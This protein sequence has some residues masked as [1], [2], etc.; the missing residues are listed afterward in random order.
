MSNKMKSPGTPKRSKGREFKPREPYTLRL[1]KILEEYPDGSQVLREILQNSDDAKS[2]EQVFIL[3]HNT[4]PSNSV[5]EPDL[6]DNYQRTNLKL[7]RYQGPALLSK[8]NTIFEERDFQ[9]LL[10]LANSEKRDQFDKIGVMGV[11]FNSIY[12]ITDSPSFIT[13]DKY[14]ILDPHEWYFEG[15]VQFDFV[16]EDLAKEYPHQFAPFRI[17]CDKP[18]KGTLFRYPLRTTEDSIDSNISKK[19]Y[20]PDEILEMFNKFYENESINCLLFLK[21]IECISFYELK[22]GATEPNLLYTIRL[23]NANRVREQRHL[24]VKK[25]VSMMDSLKSKKL[26]KSNQSHTTYVA[27]FSR[28]KGDS[29][30]NREVSSWLILN[31]L[32]DIYQVEA[33]FQEKFNKDIGEYKFIPNVGLAVPLN[34]LNIM[35][36]L[37]CFL[38]LPVSMPFQVS[39]NGYFAVSTNRR[40]LWSAADNEDLAADALARLKVTWNRYL[41]ENILP[42]AWAEFLREIPL[43]VIDI[44]PDN[45]Y[46]FW[47]IIES[48]STVNISTFCKDL[49]QNVI[50][51]LGVEDRVFKGPSSSS[52]IGKVAN[53]PAKSYLK[54]SLQEFHWL[55]LSNGYFEDPRSNYGLSKILGKIGF[56]VILVSHDIIKALKDSN[57]EGSLR[58]F[59]PAIIRTYLN[60]NRNRWNDTQDNNTT[61]TISRKEILQLFGYI[62][63]DKKF[64]ELEGFKMIPLADGTLGTLSL[65]S[66]S[67]VYIC[68]RDDYKNHELDI[69]KDQLDNFI[70]KSIDFGLYQSL[71][72]FAKAGWNLNIKVLDEVAVANMIRFS[73]K[74]SIVDRNWNLIG[75]IKKSLSNSEEIQMSDHREWVYKLWDNL[76]YRNWDLTKF[77]DIPL[78]PTSRSTLRKLNTPKKI[79]SNQTSKNIST[80]L[81]SIFEKFGAVFVEDEFDRSEVSK[82][83]KVT[84]YIIRPDDI[85]SVLNSLRTDSSYPKNLNHELKIHEASTLVDHLSNH[86]RLANK[87][88]FNSN[89]IEIIKHLPI[90]IEVDHTYSIPLLP[91]KKSWYLLPKSDE[92]TYGKVIYPSNMGGFLSTS[93]QNLS[94]I[95]E[96]IIKIPRLN[97][98]EYWKDYVIPFL[99]L[100][101]QTDLDIV[102]DKLFDKLPFLLDHDSNLKDVLGRTSFVPVGTLKMSLQQQ[103]P[104]N[105]KLAKPTELFDP[106]ERE[107]TG[108][109]FEEEQVFPAGKYGVP[110]ASASNKFF[111]N[112]KLL[113]MRSILSPDDVNSRIN[114]IVK[115]RKIP[116]VRE[117]LIH[118]KAFK[119]FKYIDDKWDT[120]VIQNRNTRETKV[121]DAL[122][123]ILETEWIP[124][125]D[126]S[127]KKIFS[128]RQNCYSQKDKYL[129]CLVTPLLEYKVKNKRF[130]K[131]LKWDTYPEVKTVLKQLEFC[132]VS[133]SNKQPPE[134]LEMICNAIYKYI[135]DALRANDETSM[136]EADFMKKCLKNHPWILCRNT[137]HPTDKVVFSLPI[138]FQNNNSS[139]VE[140]PEGYKSDFWYLFKEMG[141]RN[142][143]EIKDLIT[144]IS[145]MGH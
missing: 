62:L 66:N 10:K 101:Q 75:I 3:D 14:V 32:D 103:M 68:P 127:E 72:E 122:K 45:L 58:Y 36:R 105:I 118:A 47:P 15:G 104:D 115:K 23:E 141:V 107:I 90:F 99:Y 136:K 17:P 124:T 84:R 43:K 8:N 38:P 69:F 46:R 83:A 123:T 98:Y 80:N 140:L 111:S 35:G 56:P 12:H 129:V 59:S 30:E 67:H 145:N 65:S 70:D 11:G 132:Q 138:E 128:K 4:Y 1:R 49:L 48:N 9:S 134:H 78:L 77:E 50:N 34:W 40:S 54:S 130:L 29:M 20:K 87:Y 79:F 5:F 74:L 125:V 76:K 57:H 131:Y 82:W 110:K 126:A 117:Y 22:V 37:F 100:Q 53:I 19:V 137:L 112:L 88:H 24:I 27:S 120:F 139:F 81:S 143:L 2:T 97:S 135:N 42:K 31:Y 28:Q 51:C 21:Y 44:N 102:I 96:D 26:C 91:A 73:L 39:V 106:E 86:L 6:E 92:N 94:Y 60:Q 18:F 142:E 114:S 116:D 133:L 108:L 85:L 144:I 121:N 61:L 64:N 119:I 33:Y 52:P 13:G 93:S 113:G 55:S 95:L 89:H 16:E 7:D 25:I 71:Y 63:K 41:F 109:F